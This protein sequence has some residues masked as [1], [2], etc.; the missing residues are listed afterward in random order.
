[1]Q[2][3]GATTPK[4]PNQ[5][6]MPHASKQL[7]NV[8][9]IPPIIIALL[10]G[11]QSSILSSNETHNDMNPAFITVRFR[12]GTQTTKAW[13]RMALGSLKVLP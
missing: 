3:I 9:P 11:C 7:L 1:M 13:V 2:L 4:V 12:V 8:C 6:P 5:A 10:P